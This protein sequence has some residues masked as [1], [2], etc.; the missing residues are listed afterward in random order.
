MLNY[1]K[2]QREL[3]EPFHPNLIDEMGFLST[4]HYA[5]ENDLNSELLN[6]ANRV[7]TGNF[8][9]IRV[10]RSSKRLL[11]KGLLIKD[12]FAN[13]FAYNL[14]THFPK[15]KVALLLRH[16]FA[17]AVSKWQTQKW[18]WNEQFVK[19]LLQ[20]E[21]F[22]NRYLKPFKAAIETYLKEENY[23]LNQIL[24]WCVYNMVPLKQ[25]KPN[26]LVLLIYEEVL[27]NPIESI[28]ESRFL[29]GLSDKGEKLRI[30]SKL[31]KT[32][33]VVSTKTEN[34]TQHKAIWESH[35]SA[36]IRQKGNEILTVF[37]MQNFYDP[38]G[39]PNKTAIIDYMLLPQ[40]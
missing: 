4:Y 7:F 24:F 35:L 11:Y 5:S 40:S 32:P 19:V 36:D 23:F 14:Y 18:G 30:S 39:R 13:L 1:N 26:Q 10:D 17:V 2:R 22:C 25:F 21:D 34:F 9:N 20:N 29:L 15:I 31:I 38:E 6:V 16:P 33:S 8:Y 28:A 37:G 3:F 27:E 12:V